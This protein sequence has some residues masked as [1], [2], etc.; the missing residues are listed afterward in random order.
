MSAPP[1]F[2]HLVL[3]KSHFG[4]GASPRKPFINSHLGMKI[5]L[6][7]S[8]NHSQVWYNRG[9]KDNSNMVHCLCCDALVPL[10]H[11]DDRFVSFDVCVPCANAFAKDIS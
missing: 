10:S 7:S 11:L 8:C 5:D 9:M 3:A 2:L 6:N 4:A 1:S